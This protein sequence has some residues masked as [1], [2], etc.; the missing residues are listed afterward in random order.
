M[1][2]DETMWT[3]FPSLAT[4]SRCGIDDCSVLQLTRIA[5]PPLPD[6]PKKEKWT[7]PTLQDPLGSKGWSGTLDD[8]DSLS[9]PS[10]KKKDF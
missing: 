1:W 7:P 5:P 10:L 3:S 9:I 6:E 4:V 8:I 2:D